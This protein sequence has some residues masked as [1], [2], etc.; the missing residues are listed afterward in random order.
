MGKALFREM[1]SEKGILLIT[2]AGKH[3]RYLLAKSAGC[4]EESQSPML[5]HLLLPPPRDPV[6]CTEHLSGNVQLRE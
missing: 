5:W 6:L 2:P 4:L 1:Q 3:F